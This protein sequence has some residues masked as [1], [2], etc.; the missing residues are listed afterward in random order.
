MGF[1]ALIASIMAVVPIIFMTRFMLYARTCKLISVLTFF[2]CLVRK[3]VAPIQALRVPKGCST[4]WR[5]ILVVV[6]FFQTPK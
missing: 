6:N 2:N 5:R 3:W 1:Y 4:V